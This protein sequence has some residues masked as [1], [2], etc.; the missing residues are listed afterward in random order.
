MDAFKLD[1][2][3]E[4][5]F[6]Q[7]EFDGERVNVTGGGMIIATGIAYVWLKEWGGKRTIT[8]NVKLQSGGWLRDIP[9]DRLRL[10]NP[11]EAL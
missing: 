10:V 5:L 3:A 2:G 9:L 7:A 1:I 11:K 6:R 4:L 8:S